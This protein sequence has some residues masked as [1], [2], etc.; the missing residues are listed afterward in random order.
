MFASCCASPFWCSYSWDRDLNSWHV[1]GGSAVQIS[2]KIPAVKKRETS[3][4]VLKQPAYLGFV[5]LCRDQTKEKQ[6]CLGC[7]RNCRNLSKERPANWARLIDLPTDLSVDLY[8]QEWATTCPGILSV[9]GMGKN[10]GCRSRYKWKFRNFQ[11]DVP[12][13]LGC[14]LV[15]RPILS[16]HSAFCIIIKSILCVKVCVSQGESC[17]FLLML[18]GVNAKFP[19][20]HAN[21]DNKKSSLIIKH[22]TRTYFRAKILP[23]KGTIANTLLALHSDIHGTWYCQYFS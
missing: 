14:C 19:Q 20:I 8:M 21:L 7:S 12:T 18:G 6:K 3:Y 23:R 10:P 1:I 2:W 4:S 15:S 9:V 13:L 5:R 17:I 16:R 22:Y 11:F